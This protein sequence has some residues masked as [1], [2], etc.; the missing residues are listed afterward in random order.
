MKFSFTV[1]CSLLA[2]TLGVSGCSKEEPGVGKT[3]VRTQEVSKPDIE[4]YP[5]EKISDHTW[6]IHGPTEQPNTKNQGFMNNPVFVE[7]ADSVVVL[8]PGSSLYSGRMVLRQIKKVTDKPVSTVFDS[9]IHGDHWLGNQ[10]I[11]E[12]YP[13]AKFYA[14]PKMIEAAH[15]GEAETWI[16]LLE[17]MTE[18]A[19][20]GTV[21]VIPTEALVN[22]ESYSVGGITFKAYLSAHAHTKTDAM[23]EIVEDSVLVTGDNAF[24]KRMGR[25]DDGSFRGAIAAMELAIQ[26]NLKHYVPG[27][28]QTGGKEIAE[29]YKDFLEIVYSETGKLSEEGLQD[30]EM[31]EKIHA[32]LAAFHDWSGFEEG[33]GKQ[34]SLAVLENEQAAFE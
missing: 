24:N 25:M 22:G 26:L 13:N 11:A 30:F 1:I 6:V 14:H 7:T 34:I 28:G 21:A 17:G 31:K 8:D 3:T 16:S 9:H 4:D 19:T 12:A 20:K 5:A 33:L 27:H 32:N 10:A 29:N 23:I 18:G 2:L 15:A